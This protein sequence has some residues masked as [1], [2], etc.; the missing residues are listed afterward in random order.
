LRISF[1]VNPS[2]A[3]HL[4]NIRNE[5]DR[6]LREA[7]GPVGDVA[8]LDAPNQ[9]NVGDSLIWA[10]EYA[11]FT[12][13]GL[14]VRYESDLNSFNPRG[15]RRCMPPGTGTVLIHGGGNLGDLWT[16]HQAHRETIAKTLPDYKVVQLPQSLYFQS[17]DNARRAN[18]ILGS[19]PDFQLLLRDP[20][21]IA[22][23]ARDLPAVP[24]TFCYDMALGWETPP[25]A[26]PA[27]GRSVLVIARADREGVS[28][29]ASV[30]AGSVPGATLNVTDWSSHRKDYA[31]RANRQAVRMQ[32]RIPLL[33]GPTFQAGL[34]RRLKRIND[35]NIVEGSALYSGV[36]GAIV[37]RLHAHILAAMLD[38]PHVILDNNYGKI[39]SVY[40][41]YTYQLSTAHYAK[42]L[43]EALEIAAT[44]GASGAS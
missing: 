16:G 17:E 30:P 18:D 12:R 21:S 39:R 2:D 6:I 28:G 14:N 15:L 3:A 20:E 37:D 32:H 26:R 34:R 44:F 41:L 4:T 31:W 35:I 33:Q 42:S 29:L 38:V 43:P 9:R 5:S 13:L 10:G 19:H 24:A 36:T 25:A 27:A 40:D 11:Y 7:I 8:L 1:T 22:R 23:S